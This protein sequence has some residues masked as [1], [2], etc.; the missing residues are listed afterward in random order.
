LVIKVVRLKNEHD[1][2]IWNTETSIAIALGKIEVGPTVH[3]SEYCDRGFGLIAMDRI[4]DARKV[5]GTNTIIRKLGK[6]VDYDHL[7][8]LPEKYQY[9]FI[10]ILQKCIHAGYIHMDT[11]LENMGYIRKENAFKPCIFDFGLTQFRHHMNMV[12]SLAFSLGQILERCPIV[13]IEKTV[14]F[15]MFTSLLDI[16]PSMEA[17]K[18]KFPIHEKNYIQDIIC[19]T[20]HI[21]HNRDICIGMY[22]YTH[23]L[24]YDVSMRDD[25]E[26][27]VAISTAIYAIRRGDYKLPECSSVLSKRRIY[28]L[29][30]NKNKKPRCGFLCFLKK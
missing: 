25:D 26:A 7:D 3:W 2:N 4:I 12:Y 22:L 10:D 17:L 16:E 23:I 29:I 8:R 24:Q 14:F 28:P 27:C 5:P 30:E 6:Y 19:K 11:H 20:S 18:N 15:K 9:G 1:Y 13:T 21:K